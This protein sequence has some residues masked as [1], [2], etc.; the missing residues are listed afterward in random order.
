MLMDLR[1]GGDTTKSR[2]TPSSVI[3]ASLNVQTRDQLY[4]NTFA[5]IYSYAV[6]TIGTICV[7]SSFGST[8]MFSVRDL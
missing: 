6:A 8:V 3:Y 4:H 7:W 5:L 1:K 2:F